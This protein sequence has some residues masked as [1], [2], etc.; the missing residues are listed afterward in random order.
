MKKPLVIL[1]IGVIAVMAYGVWLANQSPETDLGPI[2][3][4]CTDEGG[5]WVAEYGECENI[6][7]ATCTE[8]G[9]AYAE[10]TSACR[11][12]DDPAA[13]CTMQCVPV[14]SFGR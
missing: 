3:S 1:I 4:I 10:C 8:L 2:A 9:G 12:S 6:G 5:S 14:C 13:P 7:A 11:H